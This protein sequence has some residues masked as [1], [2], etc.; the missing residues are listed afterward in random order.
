MTLTP[1]SSSSTERPSSFCYALPI[2]RHQLQKANNKPI[3]R[4]D[5]AQLAKALGAAKYV[6]CSART[7][8]GLNDVFDEAIL[9]A[10]EPPSIEP[11][12]MNLR[13]Q[14]AQQKRNKDEAAKQRSDKVK[15]DKQRHLE[16]LL[17]DS[18]FDEAQRMI[19]GWRSN[20]PD[21]IVKPIR[22]S[23]AY[24]VALCFVRTNQAAFLNSSPADP[25]N[26]TAC[27]VRSLHR[28]GRFI[29]PADP[30][31][32]GCHPAGRML[33]GGLTGGHQTGVCRASRCHG[34]T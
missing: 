14:T 8:W 29:D 10:L 15:A 24:R 28:S 17:G 34:T 16:Q 25:H 19:T 4:E 26:N 7:Q 3:T 21:E 33:A 11:P 23:L 2:V 31:R 30:R 13:E 27:A 9:A 12:S 6:E 20:E 18:K 32:A 5:A 1:T 22:E